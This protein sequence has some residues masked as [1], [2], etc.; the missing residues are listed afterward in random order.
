MAEINIGGGETD[1]AANLVAMLNHT[2]DGEG[3]CQ[4]AR[5]CGAVSGFQGGTDAAGGDHLP[6][7]VCHRRDCLSAHAPRG[8]ECGK[9]F[10]GASAALA[11]GEILARDHARDAHAV[12]Q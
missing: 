7:F 8:A 9:R 5:C 11:E 2:L 4:Q 1:R 3:A 6:T 12:Y 10:D